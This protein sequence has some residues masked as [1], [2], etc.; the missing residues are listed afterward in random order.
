MGVKLLVCGMTLAYIDTSGFLAHTLPRAC[1]HLLWHLLEVCFSCRQLYLVSN[2]SVLSA[3]VRGHC[4]I[5]EL[6]AH[7]KGLSRDLR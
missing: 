7:I 2:S 3:T 5:T 1:L 6:G 4:R